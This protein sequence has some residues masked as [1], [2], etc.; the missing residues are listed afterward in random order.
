MS[1]QFKTG[2]QVQIIA[3]DHKGQTAKIIKMDRKNH[4][5]MLENIG[6]VTRHLKRSQFNPRGGKKTVH[7]GIHCS[8]L[9]KVQEK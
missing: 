2:D 9:K 4:K 8:N 3:G 5:A 1:K 6:L 7:Q